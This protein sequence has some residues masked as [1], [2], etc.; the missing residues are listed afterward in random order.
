MY[1]EREVSVAADNWVHRPQLADP[2]AQSFFWNASACAAFADAATLRFAEGEP[3]ETEERHLEAHFAHMRMFLLAQ[4]IE[5]AVKAWLVQHGDDVKVL[6]SR[7]VG[8]DLYKLFVRAA[9]RGFSVSRLHS[10]FFDHFHQ[11]AP[12]QRV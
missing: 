4:G 5:L 1:K 11:C 3:S 12:R 6:K 8:H 9:S 10:I 7:K 2:T